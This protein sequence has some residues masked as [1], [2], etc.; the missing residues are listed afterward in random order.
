M[1][2][3]VDSGLIKVDWKMISGLGIQSIIMMGFNFVFYFEEVIFD[4]F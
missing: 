3:V 1:I 4:E 2:V